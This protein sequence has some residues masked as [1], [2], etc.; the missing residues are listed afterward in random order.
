MSNG[1]KILIGILLILAVIIG[2]KGAI[3]ANQDKSSENKHNGE[4]DGLWEYLNKTENENKDEDNTIKNEELSNEVL[5]NNIEENVVGK[6][7]EDSKK[8][9][10]EAENRKKAI[11]MAKDEWAISVDSYDFQAL[12]K[13]NGIYEVTVISNDYNRTT[14]AIYTVDVNAGTIVEQ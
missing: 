3:S 5:E 10:N 4:L 6:E 2:V 14:V 7:E 12:L 13:D 8:E 1:T 9:N 11:Q